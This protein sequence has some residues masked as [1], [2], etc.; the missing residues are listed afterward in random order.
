MFTSVGRFTHTSARVAIFFRMAD[1]FRR[2]QNY[3]LFAIGKF[4]P[5]WI[6]VLAN[7]ISKQVQKQYY[8]NHGLTCS[9]ISKQV[10][11]NNIMG[12]L[13]ICSLH[14]HKKSHSNEVTCRNHYRSS[15]AHRWS[16]KELKRV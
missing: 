4:M 13:N 15:R 6:D 12:P 7:L 8:A 14:F 5:S 16:G 10:Q 3:Y 2:H 1:F 9:L 11:K